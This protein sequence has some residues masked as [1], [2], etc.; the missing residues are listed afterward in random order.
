MI[1]GIGDCRE[2]TVSLTLANDSGRMTD[3]SDVTRLGKVCR[4]LVKNYRIRLAP[5]NE[6]IRL[7]RAPACWS[8][9]G[10]LT[11]QILQHTLAHLS[12][13]QSKGVLYD[14]TFRVWVRGAVF[15]GHSGWVRSDDG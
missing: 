15:L 9:H 6:E 11:A 5:V 2:Q 7:A 10:G 12:I 14:P 8:C 13:K 3:N 4:L 1:L